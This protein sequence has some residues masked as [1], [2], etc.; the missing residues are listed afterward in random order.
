MQTEMDHPNPYVMTWMGK[1]IKIAGPFETKVAAAEY[2]W[3]WSAAN[4]NNPCWQ[5]LQ[6]IH[7]FDVTIEHLGAADAM[8]DLAVEVTP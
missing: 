6:D 3:A 7:P 8:A 2:G 4:G 1:G 5:V